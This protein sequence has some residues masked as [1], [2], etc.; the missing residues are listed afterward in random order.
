ME[1]FKEVVAFIGVA[2]ILTIAIGLIVLI[3]NDNHT[4]TLKVM[5]TSGVIALICATI[6][7]GL[8]D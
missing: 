2:S 7:K 1:R 4:H 5:G 6:T 3:W 8:K